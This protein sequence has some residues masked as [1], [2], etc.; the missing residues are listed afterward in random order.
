MKLLRAKEAATIIGL[1]PVSL[2][3]LDRKGL[4][5]PVRDW[6]G[7]RR[8]RE[9]EVISFR[10]KLLRGELAVIHPSGNPRVKHLK[11]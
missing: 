9:D 1:R 5:H 7:H 10:E 4:L 2:R 3:E 11:S 8:F 6:A